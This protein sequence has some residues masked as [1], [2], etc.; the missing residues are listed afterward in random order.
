M[1]NVLEELELNFFIPP[2]VPR[3]WPKVRLFQTGRP[4]GR[5]RGKAL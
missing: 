3:D 4:G 5:Y 1:V 2:W